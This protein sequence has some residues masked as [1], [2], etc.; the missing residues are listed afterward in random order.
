MSLLDVV[1]WN[2]EHADEVL[3]A[4]GQ[5]GL[6]ETEEAMALDD[7][8]YL[9]ILS[10]ITTNARTEGVDAAMDEHELDAFIAPT[11]AVPTEIDGG[12]GF[13]GGSSK[14]ASISGYPSITVPMGM[15]RDL[16]VGLHLSGRA[17]SEERLLALAY[18]VEQLLQAR[19]PAEV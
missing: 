14:A 5:Q 9:E 19:V 15:V 1:A 2:V 10:A 4:V 3:A 8:R 17:F 11:T 13:P 6:A 12:D 18:S 7:P 16:P